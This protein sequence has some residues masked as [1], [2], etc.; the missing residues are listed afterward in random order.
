[1]PG[2]LPKTSN[3]PDTHSRII[4]RRS[5]L[6]AAPAAGLAGGAAALTGRE[7]GLPPDSDSDRTLT[8]SETPHIQ[9]YYRRARY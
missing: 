9:A 3:P 2:K 6:A 5:L 8:Y 7:E 4:D 1:M